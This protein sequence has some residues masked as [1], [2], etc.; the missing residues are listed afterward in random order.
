MSKK[1]QHQMYHI[2]QK[3]RYRLLRKNGKLRTGV[4]LY[5]V[6]KQG[7]Q[8]TLW[9]TKPSSNNKIYNVIQVSRILF[10][11]NFQ[12]KNNLKRFVDLKST[13]VANLRLK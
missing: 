5:L 10:E 3:Y 11:A 9:K 7:K 8:N 1:K 13:F 2:I 4:L 12:T 6:C